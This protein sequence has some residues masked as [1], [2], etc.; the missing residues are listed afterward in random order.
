MSSLCEVQQ[1]SFCVCSL[2]MLEDGGGSGPVP[3]VTGLGYSG[4]GNSGWGAGGA[5]L[6]D[7]GANLKEY[8]ARRD[9]QEAQAVCGPVHLISDRIQR[10][11]SSVKYNLI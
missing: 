4:G 11:L 3:G 5:G 6:W 10:L 9:E 8:Y 1:S 2:S 7:R